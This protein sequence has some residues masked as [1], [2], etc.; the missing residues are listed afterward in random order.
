MSIT[1]KFVQAFD[2]K[3][4]VH[5]NWLS[6]MMDVAESMSDPTAHIKLVEEVNKNPM[7]IVLGQR[8]ALDWAHIHFCLCA[9]YAKA[10]LRKKAFIPA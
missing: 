8:D 7:E 9:V 6:R 5:V 4:E 10:V 2:C 1:S 3:N